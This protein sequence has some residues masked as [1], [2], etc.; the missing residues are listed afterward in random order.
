MMEKPKNH[1]QSQGRGGDSDLEMIIEA[2]FDFFISILKMLVVS[3]FALVVFF[4]V[5][6]ITWDIGEYIDKRKEEK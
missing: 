4:V 1:Q 6:C 3:F 5:G 2:A